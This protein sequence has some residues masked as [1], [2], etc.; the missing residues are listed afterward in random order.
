MPN[1]KEEL[2][3]MH[4][5]YIASQRGASRLHA[6]LLIINF[7]LLIKI[8]MRGAVLCICVIKLLSQLLDNCPC[9]LRLIASLNIEKSVQDR[10]CGTEPFCVVSSKGVDNHIQQG[11]EILFIRLIYGVAQVLTLRRLLLG[12]N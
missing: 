9:I 6:L 11:E 4:V 10:F 5:C 12:D 3:I 2:S 7:R 8:D 1:N